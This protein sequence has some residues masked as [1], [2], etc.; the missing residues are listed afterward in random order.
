[1][2]HS[3]RGDSAAV[4]SCDE[5]RAKFRSDAELEDWDHEFPRKFSKQHF[6]QVASLEFQR[7]RE[8]LTIMGANGSGKTHLAIALGKK[9]CPEGVKVRF[10]PLNLLLEESHAEKIRAKYLSVT[11]RMRSVVRSK[12]ELLHAA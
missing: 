6:R 12:Q 11:E 5:R 1:V 9:L 10:C 8:N 3:Q 4:R 7:R 2:T